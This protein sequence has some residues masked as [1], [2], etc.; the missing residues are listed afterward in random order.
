MGNADFLKSVA[1]DPVAEFFIKAADALTRMQHEDG[2][3]GIGGFTG[4]PCH[5]VPAYPGSLKG[6][7][8]GDLAD[9]PNADGLVSLANEKSA[10]HFADVVDPKEMAVVALR[11]EVG[12]GV[13]ESERFAQDA[14]P[15]VHPLPI[16]QAS[17]VLT[18]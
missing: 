9:F 18:G 14:L 7:L 11:L 16:E 5:E 2:D 17:S 8:H 3:P 13:N 12:V 10:N 1:F 6:R 15:Q 4:D